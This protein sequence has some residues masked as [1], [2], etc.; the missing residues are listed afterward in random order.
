VNTERSRSEPDPQYEALRWIRYSEKPCLGAT[1]NS[2]ASKVTI[3]YGLFSFRLNK[4]RREKKIYIFFPYSDFL[5]V[6][7]LACLY[8][9]INHNS[10]V[11]A[12]FVWR[13]MM[14]L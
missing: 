14:C 13:E 6:V 1:W 11:V 7:K 12:V 3:Y 4:G 8:Q 2:G 5:R 10:D 9:S